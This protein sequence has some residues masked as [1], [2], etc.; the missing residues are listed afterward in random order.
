M[1]ERIALA[2]MQK[3][4]ARHYAESIVDTVR[5]P[6]LVLDESL[7]VVSANRSFYRRFEVSAEETQGRPVYHLGNGQWDIPELRRLLEEIIPE[8]NSFEDFEVR[9]EFERIGEK[10]MRLNA[11]RVLRQEGTPALVLL[12][13]EDITEQHSV[14]KKLAESEE[15]YRRLVEEINSIII[16]IDREGRITFFNTFSEKLFG[17]RRDE[18]IGKPFV[19]TIVPAVDSRGTD[20]TKL[21]DELI[22]NPLR[23]YAAESQG[24]RKDGGWIQF[25]WSAI[26]TRADA[27]KEMEILIDGNDVTE[28]AEARAEVEA[29]SSL[30]DALLDFIPEGI[31]ITDANHVVQEASRRMGEMLGVPVEK[32]LGTDEPG[33]L[34]LAK[35]Y[36]PDGETLVQPDELPLSKALVTG[37]RYTDYEVVAKRDGTTRVLAVNAAPIRD[38]DGNVVGAIGGWRDVTEARRREK[39]L[40]ESENRFRALVTASAYV[41]YRMS[42]EWDQLLEL[43]G[44][45][46]LADTVQPSRTWLER[47]ILSEDR[48]RFMSRV[49]E[50]IGTRS[51]FELEHRV[52][53]ADGTV[54]WTLSRAI[55]LVG[56]NGEVAEWFGAAVDITDRK[57]TE[58]ELSRNR[59]LLENVLNAVPDGIVFADAQG[60]I[61]YYNPA[62]YRILGGPVTGDAA[63]PKPGTY[64][65]LGPD[66]QPFP[67]EKLPLVR[68]VQTDQSV[69]DVEMTVRRADGTEIFVL[70]GSVPVRD[71]Q[72]RVTGAVASLRDVTERK[73]AEDA[74]RHSWQM[75]AEGEALSHTGAWECDLIA[76]RWSFS[77]E[78]LSI[79]GLAQRTLSSQQ[80]L[81]IAHPDDRAAVAR[82]MEHLRTGQAAYDMEH[83][84]IRRNDGAVRVVHAR[85]RFV[86]DSGG[87]VTKS[88]GFAQDITERKEAEEALLRRTQELVAANRDL[89]AFSYSVSHDLRNPLHTIGSFTE[90]LRELY[91]QQLGEEGRDCLRRI[92]EGVRKMNRLIED[93]LNLSRVGRQELKREDVD[94]S[95]MVRDFSEELQN[96]QPQRLASF[97]IE[98]RVHANGD[99]SMLRMALQNLLRNAWKFTATKEVARIEFGTTEIDG[100]TVYYVRDNG[101]GFDIQFAQQIF[102]PF[103]RVHTEKEFH[104]TGVGLSIVQR[105]INRHGG[106]V[107][108]ESEV[109]KGAGFYFTLG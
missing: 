33:R 37:R 18:V 90:V 52:V 47:Y 58:K 13:I 2:G 91:S 68:T 107:W 73:R 40:R 103:K 92:D 11:R 74:V 17:Y 31:L 83:R 46:F 14:R 104:G 94:L 105:V 45:D 32:L 80:L 67:P 97:T 109:G 63:T 1:E 38:A 101:V 59:A 16:G 106:E 62:A 100:R 8:Q 61:N 21:I 34:R 96:S 29:K 86:R 3:D 55:P 44:R 53:R 81:A 19:G 9:H 84:I 70:A 22:A 75:L 24:V 23:F 89:E 82:A 54:G 60:T 4:E 10:V 72:G 28:L 26:V 36:R 87:K 56:E 30:L 98:D 6:L 35:L 41:V 108:A 64:E 95:A 99:P 50:A 102:A 65:L 43:H 69:S 39:E 5:E 78:W 93:M 51:V 57:R 79:H 27:G 76:D 66:G 7:R 12:A 85:G 25:S 71:A 88:Y 49:R 20:N 42:P 15:R 77:D 48:P